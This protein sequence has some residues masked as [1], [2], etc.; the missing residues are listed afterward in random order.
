MEL[1]T[2]LQLKQTQKLIMTPTLIQRIQILQMTVPELVNEIQNEILENPLIE[3]DK[4]EISD[5]IN[6]ET[7][8]QLN[9]EDIIQNQ[10][11]IKNEFD[12]DIKNE[13]NIEN[14]LDYKKDNDKEKNTTYDEKANENSF[15]EFDEEQEKEKDV[16]KDDINWEEYLEDVENT[17][18]STSNEYEEIE[19][20]SFEKYTPITK[21]LHDH[22]IEQLNATVFTERELKIG[23]VIIGFINSEGY[24]QAKA[25]EIIQHIDIVDEN[26]SIEEVEDLIKTIQSFDPTGICARNLSE[27]LLI[28]LYSLDKNMIIPDKLEEII[29]N[30][31]NDIADKNYTKVAKELNIT[32]KEVEECVEFIIKNF[33]PKPGLVYPSSDDKN[34]KIIPEVFIEKVDGEYI[35]K[36]SD[37]NIP[38]IRFN[39]RYYNILK[40]KQNESKELVSFIEKSYN[41]V[42]F[43][44]DAIEQ[45]RQTIKKVV[46]CIVKHQKDFFEYGI[47][48]MKP[49]T[50]N[51]V[52]TEINMDESTVSRVTSKKYALTPRG[53]YE[54]KFFFLKGLKSTTD[55]EAISVIKVKERIKQII[56]NEPKDKPYSDQDIADLLNNEGIQ[57]ARRTVNKYRE[58]LNIPPASKRKILK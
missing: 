37:Y 11:N 41:K 49:L 24:L 42:K 16:F 4:S 39:R 54:L 8:E 52:A 35:V 53:V 17:T 15:E 33:N 38:K 26:A 45:R 5:E 46:E 40:N 7:I 48:Y 22:L 47:N 30:Y 57:I 3:P 50:L 58:E 14:N 56:A 21:T 12:E 32:T 28:Q 55:S 36:V 20:D 43:L 34:T 1:N 25:E 18:S 44:I 29:K 13:E 10:N 2:S 9:I 31:L 6:E 27:C 19:Y 23:K 51:D